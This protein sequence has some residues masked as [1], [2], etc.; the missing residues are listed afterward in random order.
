MG[1]EV[2]RA[3]PPPLTPPRFTGE[4]NTKGRMGVFVQSRIAIIP[5]LSLN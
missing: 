3:K 4:G 1:G 5:A 2:A